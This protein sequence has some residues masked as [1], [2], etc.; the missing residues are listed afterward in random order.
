ME[1]TLKSTA[2]V[3]SAGVV[4]AER[5]RPLAVDG[6]RSRAM[7]ERIIGM[8]LMICG[9]LSILT[10]A[11]IVAVLIFETVEF[12]RMVSVW[13]Y[14][15]STTWDPARNASAGEWGVLPLISAT[16]AYAL[17][18]LLLSVPVGLAIAIYLSEYAP[19]AIRSVVKPV[20][21][22]LAGVPTIVYG[23]FAL[24]FLTPQILQRF[25]ST[26]GIFNVLAGGLAIGVLTIPLVASLSEDAMRAV[27][28][29]L[30]EGAFALGA[31]RFETSMRVILP[32]AFSGVVASIIL[33]LGRAVGETM[34]VVIAGGAQTGGVPTNL[35]ASAQ[36]MTS[37]IVN[38]L[39]GEASRGGDARYYS[40][41]A[42]GLTLLI[43]TLGLNLISR[44]LIRRFREVYE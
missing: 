15:T 11:G 21:E 19:P 9:G 16:L 40:L 39:G 41:F 24:T 42:I 43:I 6:R 44:A 31:T 13:E 35:F 25:D 38:V 27:P 5:V 36:S 4:V 28:R 29:S 23:F 20:L 2:T 17:V 37:Y 22:L 33:A 7:S 30:R 10:T 1:D 26:I 3:E 34:I 14:L 8:V 12:F 18:G 32:A